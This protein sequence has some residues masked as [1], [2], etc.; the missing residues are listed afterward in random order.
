MWYHWTWGIPNKEQ[1]TYILWHTKLTKWMNEEEDN[2]E[3]N[4]GRKDAC[5]LR[6]F[7]HVWHCVTL[8]I[9]PYQALLSMEFFRQEYWSGLP[10]PLPGDLSH[11]GIESASLMSPV[12]AGRFLASSTT[13]KAQEGRINQCQK[14]MYK[15]RLLKKK[16][17][18][19]N[20]T[21]DI[22]NSK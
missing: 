7:S 5:M 18:I 19:F 1:T 4:Q 9:V 16:K 12:L 13:W 21:F 20:S 11:P 6:C 14:L 10:C 22:L 17:A 2:L 8:Q 3:F 15:Q